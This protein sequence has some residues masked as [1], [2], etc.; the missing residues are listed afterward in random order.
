MMNHVTTLTKLA[1]NGLLQLT[2]ADNDVDTW[3]RDTAITEAE[4]HQ[5]ATGQ[6]LED[7]PL[8]LLL[9]FG[10]SVNSK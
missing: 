5:G 2:S 9:C 4:L 6:G 1:N 3:L 8:W 10:N 7:P